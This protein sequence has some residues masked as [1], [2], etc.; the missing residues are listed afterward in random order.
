MSG[1]SPRP[2]AAQIYDDL[3][4]RHASAVFRVA[5]RLTGDHEDAE[6]LA[7][8]AF[9]EAWRSI[10]GL[11]APAAGR[12][13]LMT[14]LMRRAS[15]RLRTVRR[16]PVTERAIEESLD[17][18]PESD[19]LLDLGTR[20]EDIQSALDSLDPSRRSVFLLVCLEGMTCRAAAEVLD[21][22]LGTALSRIHRARSELRWTLR[23][24]RPE[25]GKGSGRTER[26][27]RG[28]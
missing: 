16:D 9:Y 2:G 14:I 8:E 24:M 10:E 3:V 27:G 15:R 18:A 19:S 6:D 13:W 7:Q 21:I 1:P 28:S 17:A 5:F 20:Q 23:H 25:G 22:P 4:R 26:E 12:A 11:R